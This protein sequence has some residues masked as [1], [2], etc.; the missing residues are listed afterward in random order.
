[1]VF[2]EGEAV[3]RV[4][5]CFIGNGFVDV[6]DIFFVILPFVNGLWNNN[7]WQY[8]F[9]IEEYE[10]KEV[11]TGRINLGRFRGKNIIVTKSIKIGANI[12]ILC[13][14]AKFFLYNLTFFN[15]SSLVISNKAGIALP[16]RF[17]SLTLSAD[18]MRPNHIVALRMVRTDDGEYCDKQK[19]YNN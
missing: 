3:S 9:I 12:Y 10:K 14:T 16:F 7:A 19:N 13:V 8:L 18:T 2:S 4:K 11:D 6:N 5:K 1:M 17:F 15:I